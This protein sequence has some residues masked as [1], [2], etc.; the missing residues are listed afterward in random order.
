MK[1]EDYFQQPEF[2]RPRRLILSVEGPQKVGKTTLALTAADEGLLAL[3]NYDYGLEG[4]IDQFKGKPIMVMNLDH[5]AS[6]AKDDGMAEED[7]K[8]AW[9]KAKDAYCTALNDKRVKVVAVDT[10]SELWEGIRLSGLGRL[11]KVLPQKYGEVNAEMRKLIRDAYERPDLNLILLH[12]MRDEYAGN[13]RTGKQI[14]SGFQ[15][16]PGLVQMVLR[17]W[18]SGNEYGGTI[19]DCRQKRALEGLDLPAAV[20]TFPQLLRLVH[21]DAE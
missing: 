1:L 14:F 17:M 9:S 13:E 8:K 11:G 5:P 19:I 12:P 3:L 6:M 7:Y 21:G 20:L 2:T 18:K 16:V 4:V 15:G 10:G